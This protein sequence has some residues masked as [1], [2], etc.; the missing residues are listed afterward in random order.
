MNTTLRCYCNPK[1]HWNFWL[2]A[3]AACIFSTFQTHAT[4]NNNEKGA[5]KGG[6]N[7]AETLLPKQMFPRLRPQEKLVSLQQ[8]IFYSQWGR[9][10]F[11]NIALLF[12]CPNHKNKRSFISTVN[13]ALDG[14]IKTI[15][16]VNDIFLIVISKVLLSVLGPVVQKPINANPRLKINQENYFSTPKCCLKLIFGKT[17]H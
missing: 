4:T 14:S 17:L 2:I 3:R 12:R 10:L 6:N 11:T 8:S 15:G 7:V 5:C 1:E 13:E 16:D 9:Y